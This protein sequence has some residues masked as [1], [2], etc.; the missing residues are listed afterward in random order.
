MS[1]KIITKSKRD[2]LSDVTVYADTY[3][4][5]L[6]YA[7]NLILQRR[8]E[9]G[10]DLDRRYILFVPD[11]YTLYAE[12]LIY[13]NGGAFD[14]EVLTVNRL[15]FKL[16]EFCGGENSRPLSRLGA[17]LTVR[18][19]LSENEDKLGCFKNSAKFA[20]FGEVMYDN[21]C[22]LASSGLTP[23]DLPDC[24]GSIVWQKL[25][26]VKL[27]Y[28][29][30]NKETRNKYVDASGRLLLLNKMLGCDM[31]Y[32]DN[33]DA[34]FA[35]YDGFT[36]LTEQ[37]VNKICAYCGAEHS[38]VI[39]AECRLNLKG[40]NITEYEATSRADELK[41]AARRICDLQRR[42]VPYSD[43]GVIAIGADFN[44]L[45]R[46]FNEYNVPY[47]TDEKYALASHPLPRYLLDL[48]GTAK[49]GTNENYIKLSK[50][51]Y[52][53][54]ARDDADMFEN[55]I[56]ALSLPEWAMSRQIEYNGKNEELRETVRT[57]ERVRSKLHKAVS[58][59][60]RKEIKSGADFYRAVLNAI[61]ENESEISAQYDKKF[62]SARTETESAAEVIAEVYA[63]SASFDKMYDAL[64]ECFRLKEVGVIPN[65]SGV[66]EVGEVSVF[67][68]S[69]KKYL[70]VL[71]M[72]EGEVPCVMRDDGIFSDDD[73]KLI[74]GRDSCA[75]IEPSIAAL[76]KRAE[77]EL[78]SVLTSSGDLFLSCVA[79]STPSSALT[80]IRSIK[81]NPACGF[82]YKAS[83]YDI[84]LSKLYAAAEKGSSAALLKMCPTPDS[85]AELYLCGKND[86][87][88]G[89]LGY[90]YE[91]ELK[92]ALTE[93]PAVT[94]RC[95]GIKNASDLYFSSRLSVS[96][97]QEFF[98]CP[99]RCFM[100]YGLR[101]EPRPDGTVSPLDLGTFLHRVIELFVSSGDYDN[102]SVSVPEI[103]GKIKREETYFPKAASDGFI[104]ELT[105]E[106]V[107]V[108]GVVANQIRAGSFEAKFTELTFGKHDGGLK[109]LTM[110]INCGTVT[111]DGVIDRIDVC[112]A[113]G[114]NSGAVRVI[115]YKTGRSEFSLSDIYHGRKI[116]LPVYLSV[117]E[118]N[119]YT[120]A[121]MFYFPFASAFAENKN[122]YRLSGMFDE[123]YSFEMD[124]SLMN[125][126]TSS[127]VVSARSTKK[128][129]LDGCVKTVKSGSV[130]SGDVLK[131]VC[132]YASEVFRTGANEMLTGYCAPS[133][134]G[135]GR[136][137]ECTY[138]EVKAACKALNKPR[139][140]RIKI[141]G[142]KADYLLRCVRKDSAA[143]QSETVSSDGEA[144]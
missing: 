51:P 117:A 44:R 56:Y 29:L 82:N 122:S 99:F 65:K 46:I 129:G 58:A 10:A 116:Q 14:I 47:F 76:N 128:S 121:G 7:V 131:A 72:H 25:K 91:P 2:A 135:S 84:E 1:D 106:A 125:P 43:I 9:R 6:K 142:I 40:K 70:F 94:D 75:A 61:P 48:F 34:V 90:G 114:E 42:G 49:S 20:G 67:R 87:D 134:L 98:A 55:C 102:P 97:V 8:R 127:T 120:P 103:V 100:R 133:P 31:S 81:N 62:P 71:G 137:S 110:D 16:C 107:R 88:A 143:E 13:A 77:L 113:D 52:S 92:A 60:G 22:Q 108:A 68:A 79:D 24:D 126:D 33:T 11:K 144:L 19:I 39:K 32:F 140:D 69:E 141:G 93:L 18:K 53:G 89:G 38:A 59:V 17:I 50:N 95:D 85:A 123:K 104:A 132:E 112:A 80:F 21:I 28:S 74:A 101:A 4:E 136:T 3:A 36:P 130:V 12:K 83:S 86:L 63:G 57:A 5:S 64:G 66:V 115:D 23:E 139:R 30:Y 45:R 96:R 27:V 15:C 119:G 35:C 73:L 37:I 138:C 54:I 41:A 109:G 26:A 78:Y 111:V 105:E 118:F 124:N